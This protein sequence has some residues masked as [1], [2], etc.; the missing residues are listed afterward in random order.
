MGRVIWKLTQ[1][2][3]GKNFNKRARLHLADTVFY[4]GGLSEIPDIYKKSVCCSISSLI[5]RRLR[6]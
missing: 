4:V 2:A 3:H 5:V 6:M 1:V